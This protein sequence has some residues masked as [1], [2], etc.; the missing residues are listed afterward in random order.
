KTTYIFR[1]IRK[2][3]N[4]CRYLA[5]V[6]IYFLAVSIPSRFSFRF[7]LGISLRLYGLELLFTGPILLQYPRSEAWI[8]VIIYFPLQTLFRLV[9]LV[10]P[11]SRMPQL[12]RNLFHMNQNG[13]VLRSCPLL[14]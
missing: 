4:K 1:F 11:R 10:G 2:L 9:S 14:R 13:H 3:L 5:I 12:L 8:T 6:F 7:N